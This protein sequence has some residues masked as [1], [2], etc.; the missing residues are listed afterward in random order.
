MVTTKDNPYDPNKDFD[1]WYV[2]DTVN[3]YNTLSV[4]ASMANIS[5]EYSD[6]RAA[7]EWKRAENELLLLFPNLY[8]RIAEDP[9][10]R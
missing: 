5:V 8:K 4:L 3:G 1:E 10:S 2:F 9:A 6:E 7:E